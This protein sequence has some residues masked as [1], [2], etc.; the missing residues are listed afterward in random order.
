MALA[1]LTQ[2]S[3]ERKLREAIMTG[4]LVDLRVG[5]ATADDPATGAD[6]P[7]QRTVAAALLAKVLTSTEGP[8]R[9]R[10][11][12][13]AGARIVGRLD[14][15]ATEVVCP[16]LLRD[17]WFAEPVVLDEAQAPA[18]RL[19]GCHL[20]GL[21]AQQLALRGNLELNHGFTAT[22]EVS[23]AGSHIGGQLDFHGAILTN[24]TGLALSAQGITIDHDLV[25]TAGFT[26]TGE[27]RLLG[28]H[29]G[30]ELNFNGASLTNANGAA[31]NADRVT[32]G[33]D[34]LC[35]DGFTATGEVRIV[36]ARI[37]GQLGLNGA[38]LTNSNRWVLNLYALRAESLW[39]L[40]LPHRPRLVSF[41][42]AQVGT[43]VDEPNSWPHIASLDGF[44]YDDLQE[45]S[46]VSA[47]QRL[48]W[49]ARNLGGYRPQPYE[50]L[51]AA[52]RRAGRDEDAHTVAIAKQWRRRRTLHPLGKLWN[53]LLYVTV[54][55]GYRMWLAIVWLL[56]FVGLGWW[57]FDRVHPAHLIAAKPPGQ[58][59]P[60]HAAVYALDLLLPFA[61]L[62]YQGAWIATGSARWLFVGWNL[63]GWV[64][65]TA[66]VAALTGLLKREAHG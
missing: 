7:A 58:R 38:S 4:R 52:Y 51:V 41:S 3:M 59:P 57:W 65:I 61:D 34:M 64:L 5:D 40:D 46:S 2:R 33:Q 19:P 44:A 12:R 45:F 49:L 60:F 17:C 24:P 56:A 26:A 36:G 14:L 50:Q 63:A 30:G 48:W 20:P 62:G 13:L 15:E 22:G 47:R 28:A 27:V 43:L 23:L 35:Q 29:I 11:L 53:L 55:Y 8:R 21:L 18:L 32:V 9:P 39:L 16:L 10:A 66:V 54:G 6:W 1:H 31:L 42:S 37:S 25:C